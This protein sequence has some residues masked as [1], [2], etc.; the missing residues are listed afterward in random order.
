MADRSTSI[1]GNQIENDSVKQDELDITN[2]P[3]D[4]QILKINMPT[5]DF[6]AIDGGGDVTAG[7]NITDNAIV[8]GDGGSKGIQESTARISDDGEITNT[9]QPAFQV[10]PSSN[11]TNIAVASDVTVV[12]GTERFDQ[13][14]NFT[15]N[16]FTAPVSGKYQLNIFL[17]SG[18]LDSSAVLYELRITTSNRN[19]GI[20]LDPLSLAGDTGAN[21]HTIS[22]SVVA[23]MDANDTAYITVYQAGG[24]QQFG[25]YGGA[26]TALQTYFSGY[27]LG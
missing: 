21:G 13:G 20:Y 22:G 2:T 7:S 24:A 12:F 23:D 25:I 10:V 26:S 19:Y 27:L 14:S 8:R 5:G 17:Q 9:S 11:Q 18:A 4:G 3:S 1:P 6:T 15:S 16:T